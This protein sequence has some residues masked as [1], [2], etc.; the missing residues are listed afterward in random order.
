MR[1]PITQ[2]MYTNYIN[3]TTR[4]LITTVN[5]KFDFT[6][7]YPGILNSDSFVKIVKIPIFTTPFSGV[8]VIQ[9]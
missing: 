5:S 1:P 4:D 2:P 9:S 3:P 7:H 8:Q 6:C